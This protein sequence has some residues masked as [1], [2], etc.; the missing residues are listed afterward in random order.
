MTRHAVSHRKSLVH[1]IAACYFGLSGIF[2][3]QV[4]IDDHFVVVGRLRGYAVGRK[5]RAEKWNQGPSNRMAKGC[6]KSS[7]ASVR[8]P[9]AYVLLVLYFRMRWGSL[10]LSTNCSA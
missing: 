2:G 3:N 1:V 8:Y 6:A 10:A 5:C 7:G 9:V 4:P